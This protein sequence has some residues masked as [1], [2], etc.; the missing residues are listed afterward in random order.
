MGK[1]KKNRGFIE[2]VKDCLDYSAQKISANMAPP[3][4]IE[5]VERIAQSLENRIISI[6]E[7]L[8]KKM[9]SFVLIGF[10]VIFL[11]FALFFFLREFLGWSNSVGFFSIGIVMLA[12]GL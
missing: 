1:D 12:I 11:V 3:I 10:G 7:R 6:E 5:I 4:I 2:V 9:F 8:M